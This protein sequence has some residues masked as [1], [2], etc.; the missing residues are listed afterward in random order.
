MPVGAKTSRTQL[1]MD[2][3]GEWSWPGRAAEAVDALP[4]AWVP[5]FPPRL[6]AAT[7]GMPAHGSSQQPRAIDELRSARPVIARH[8]LNAYVYGGESDDIADPS[9]NAPFAAAL[10]AA[11]ATAHSAVYPGGHTM[12]TLQAH[13]PHM[14]AYVGRALTGNI[15]SQRAAATR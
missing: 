3:L 6:E 11:G 12:Q 8:G 2:S 5:A 4:P 7:A 15:R 13:L 14:L 10:R 9:E 1:W